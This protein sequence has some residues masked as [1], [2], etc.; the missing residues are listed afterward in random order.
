MNIEE[1][2]RTI[3]QQ[4]VNV[5]LSDHSDKGDCLRIGKGR[6]EMVPF[7]QQLAGQGF[8]GMVTLEL[9]REAFGSAAELAED[10]SRLER[11]MKKVQIP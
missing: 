7:M 9:Y 3:G 1:A 5:H 4:I 6:F 11:L 8:V 2:V 10:Y